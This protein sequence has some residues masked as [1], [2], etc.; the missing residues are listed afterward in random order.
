MTGVA[1]AGGHEITKADV[2]AAQKAWGD[3]LVAIAT[4]YDEHGIEKAK[5]VALAA[6]E[7]LY[8]YDNA[9][10]LF[11][12]T[13]AQAPHRF[14]TSKEGA[15]AYFIGGDPNFPA[16]SG[17]ALR[18]WRDVVVDNAAIFTD[19][20]VGISMSDVTF[21]DV[22]GN[23]VSVDKTLGFQKLENGDVVIVLHHSSLPYSE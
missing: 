20:R 9:P 3:A 2:I 23:K 17:F 8:N 21:T 12:P 13:L 14:R 15:I 4:A 18:S 5:E 7:K 11:K 22:N 16:D 19:G 1:I 10:V 6:I